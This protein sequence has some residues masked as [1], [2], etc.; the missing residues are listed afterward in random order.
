MKNYIFLNILPIGCLEYILILR[1][2]IPLER[3]YKRVNCKIKSRVFK[4]IR[5][6]EFKRV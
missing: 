2:L 5:Y 6:E 1:L 4:N 3:L